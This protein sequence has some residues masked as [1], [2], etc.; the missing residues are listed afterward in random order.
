MLRAAARARLMRVARLAT[1]VG[2]HRTHA[3]NAGAIAHVVDERPRAVQ[4]RGTEIIALP[5]DDVARRVA[6]RA[7]DALDRRVDR[8]ALWRR[9][10]DLRKIVLAGCRR[11]ELALR[12]RPFVEE[13]RHVDDEI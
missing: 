2:G 4:R 12:G 6:D 1:A 10:R 11:L 7:T 8:P 13:R 5:A 9:G 3:R